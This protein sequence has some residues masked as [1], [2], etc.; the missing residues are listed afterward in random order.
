LGVAVLAE[1]SEI[2]ALVHLAGPAVRAA[3]VV[4]VRCSW[5]GALVEEQDVDR[6]EWSGGGG[7]PFIDENGDPRLRWQGLVAISTADDG[8]VVGKWAV[9]DP[10]D[11]KIPGDSCMALDPAVTG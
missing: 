3:N 10:A 9:D 1:G 6:V 7:H 5:C 4:R 8:A 2:R 11:G